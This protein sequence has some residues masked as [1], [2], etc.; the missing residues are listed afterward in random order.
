[1]NA[2]KNLI[3]AKDEAKHVELLN[4]CNNVITS[5]AVF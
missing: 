5:L 2:V 4:E 1:M 3:N